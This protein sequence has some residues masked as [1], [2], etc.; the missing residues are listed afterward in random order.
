MVVLQLGE[1]MSTA[2]VSF[3][4]D[5]CI[6]SSEQVVREFRERLTPVMNN[7]KV[8]GME[9]ATWD[10]SQIIRIVTIHADEL[11]QEI[12]SKIPDSDDFS[13]DVYFL[14]EDARKSIHWRNS[15]RAPK[16]SKSRALVK[17]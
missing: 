11:M 1:S 13:Y 10:S 15:D 16:V 7:F 6:E 14:E 4:L 5:I 17:M 8:R 3:C 9:F 2:K 12:L